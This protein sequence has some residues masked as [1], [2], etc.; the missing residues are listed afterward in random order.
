MTALDLESAGRMFS[1]VLDLNSDY[2][3]EAGRR[4]K[5]VQKIQRATPGTATGRK[6]ALLERI[7]RADAAALFMEELKIDSL[8]ARRAMKGFDTTFKDPERVRAEKRPVTATDISDHPL[9]ADIEALLR[10]GTR[11]LD[12]YPD[13]TFRPDDPWTGPAMPW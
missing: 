9:R 13:G 6:V 8:Y 10:I 3:S 12:V 7:T 11:G 1:R 2:A 4:W 5:L